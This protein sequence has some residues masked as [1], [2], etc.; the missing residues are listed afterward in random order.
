MYSTHY[1]DG[2]GSMRAHL[3]WADRRKYIKWQEWW[4]MLEIYNLT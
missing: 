2:D 1:K 4:H 3:L